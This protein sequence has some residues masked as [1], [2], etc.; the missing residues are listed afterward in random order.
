MQA[1][2]GEQRAHEC[3]ITDNP[4]HRLR[5]GAEDAEEEACEAG[6]VEIMGQSSDQKKY[7]RG[8]QEVKYQRNRMQ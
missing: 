7:Q 6:D 8:I 1:D 2:E 4:D 3:M 5:I